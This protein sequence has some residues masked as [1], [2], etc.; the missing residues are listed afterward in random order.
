MEYNDGSVT[1]DNHWTNEVTPE[2]MEFSADGTVHVDLPSDTYYADG[3][4]TVPEYQNDYFSGGI[5][6]DGEDDFA[7]D[8]TF[9]AKNGDTIIV[10]N[11]D[12]SEYVPTVPSA[13]RENKY[14]SYIS[15]INQE[16]NRNQVRFLNDEFRSN[17]PP[18][19]RFVKFVSK[20]QSFLVTGA[21]LLSVYMSLF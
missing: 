17:D 12:V 21:S 20:K 11:I 5:L 15:C 19:H 16:W 3:S 9:V 10:G 2:P 8:F 1:M 18:M 4:F 7:K 13:L 14:M 6:T